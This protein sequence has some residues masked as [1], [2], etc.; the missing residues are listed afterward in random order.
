MPLGVCGSYFKFDCTGKYLKSELPRGPACVPA[1]PQ[2]KWGAWGEHVVCGFYGL[3]VSTAFVFIAFAS[4]HW[5]GPCFGVGTK[6]LSIGSPFHAIFG[7]CQ[8]MRFGPLS[9]S[10]S[11][12]KSRKT[13]HQQQLWPKQKINKINNKIFCALANRK[14]LYSEHKICKSQRGGVNAVDLFL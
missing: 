7:I 9:Q 14:Q 8:Q 2:G 12:E 13:Q 3:F 10:C 4:C 11:L 5:N 1:F 6:W